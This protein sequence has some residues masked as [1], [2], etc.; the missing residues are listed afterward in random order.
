[1]EW[2]GGVHGASSESAGPKVSLTNLRRASDGGGCGRSAQRRQHS[3]RDTRSGASTK[4]FESLKTRPDWTATRMGEGESQG[5][6]SVVDMRRRCPRQPRGLRGGHGEE[7][8]LSAR[9]S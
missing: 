8:A 6:G 9:W 3:A 1:M 5:L 4:S 2:S 7:L